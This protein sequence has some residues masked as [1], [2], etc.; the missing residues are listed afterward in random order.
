MSTDVDT[1]IGINN[2]NSYYKILIKIIVF[3]YKTEFLVLKKIY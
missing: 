1:S 3:Y 2:D